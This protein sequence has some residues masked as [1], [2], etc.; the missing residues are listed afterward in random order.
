MKKKNHKESSETYIACCGA[1]CKTCKPYIEGHCKGCKLGYE[2]N[3]R[4]INKAKCK[5]KLCCF[6]NNKFDTCAECD[7]F[8]SC[9]IF[10]GRFKIGTR[11]HKKYQEALLF[12][13]NN[14]Y[15]KFIELADKWKGP[16]G[17]LK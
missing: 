2:P 5:I 3:K 11:N 15:S 1:Y 17:K 13:K 8:I 6:R 16:N 7:K 9:K 10:N 14:G 4:D 12:M